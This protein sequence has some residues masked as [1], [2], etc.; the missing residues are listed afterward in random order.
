VAGM[1]PETHIE[2]VQDFHAEDHSGLLWNWNTLIA[3]KPKTL[4]L[5]IENNCIIMIYIIKYT[6]NLLFFDAGWY[7]L[8]GQ[9]L[10]QTQTS[11]SGVFFQSASFH[12]EHGRRFSDFRFVCSD[13]EMENGI[14]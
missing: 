10:S 2:S 6:K 12:P 1:N 14:Q 7:C 3:K 4:L 13:E 9:T 11:G 8:L 5:Y